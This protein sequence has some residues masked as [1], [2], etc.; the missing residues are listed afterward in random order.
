MAI[1]KRAND[2]VH[3][4]EA[5]SI[6]LEQS[7]R[8]TKS[9]LLLLMG[10][11]Y[12]VYDAVAA[13]DPLHQIEL[14][15]FG[16]H[17]WPKLTAVIGPK[18]C[19]ILDQRFK[20]VPLYPG[21]KHFPNGVTSLQHVRGFEYATIL[22]LLAPLVE[23]LLPDEYQE[24]TL[25]T[26][27][28]L[29]RIH[30]LSRF[31]TH[32]DETL[33]MLD[34]QIRE[35]GSLWQ[36][37]SSQ[38]KTD[39][40]KSD[41]SAAFP[42]L[43]ILCHATNIIRNKSTSDNYE[44]DLGEGLH[45]QSKDDYETTNHQPGFEDQMLQSYRERE[46]MK[47]KRADILRYAEDKELHKREVTNDDGP[48]VEL[49][50]K[51]HRV[52][53][54]TFIK[55]LPKKFHRYKQQLQIFIHEN[56]LGLGTRRL[57]SSRNLPSLSDTYVIPYRLLRIAYVSLLD[58]RDGLDL[59]RS[60]SKWRRHGPRH[61]FVIVQ[62]GDEGDIWFAQLIHIFILRFNNVK[63]P[64]AYIRRFY[65]RPCRNALTGYIELDDRDEH[66]FIF[67]DSIV[68]SCVLLSPGAYENR[69]VVADLNDPDMFIRLSDM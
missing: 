42:K 31:T 8:K 49:G 48:R 10:P 53:T 26:I 28:A 9:Y 6:R 32:T 30:L 43:H 2:A 61:D 34:T 5:K 55:E 29:A 35:F 66:A 20:D 65:T 14:G 18:N 36:D 54:D 47:R 16:S 46:I 52:A 50:S 64:I 3:K 37:F 24:T 68:R 67:T 7:L 40:L 27:R 33:D 25:K 51:R 56:I 41:V 21:L 13:V 45:P 1:H 23:D 59:V 38:F 22:H 44:T 62:D 60:T 39:E 58:S 19:G 17:L 63:Y 69:L 11:E 4:T 15:I 57:P 12:S